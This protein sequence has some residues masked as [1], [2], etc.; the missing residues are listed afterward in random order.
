MQDSQ[1]LKDLQVQL[2]RFISKLEELERENKYLKEQVLNQQCQLMQNVKIIDAKYQ[3]IHRKQIKQIKQRYLKCLYKYG[4]F[5]SCLN[6]MIIQ[7]NKLIDKFGIDDTI[8]MD[9]K[10]C[11]EKYGVIY[12]KNKII[13]EDEMKII[14]NE[15]IQKESEEIHTLFFPT[16]VYQYLTDNDS[17]Q[18]T[19]TFQSLQSQRVRMQNSMQNTQ[20]MI[21]DNSDDTI[22]NNLTTQRYLEKLQFDYQ[23]D[24]TLHYPKTFKV[25]KLL[26]QTNRDL[27]LQNVTDRSQKSKFDRKGDSK[28]E[29]FRISPHKSQN[30]S[31]LE[32]RLKRFDNQE[33]EGGHPRRRSRADRIKQQQ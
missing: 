31:G 3:Q 20:E 6:S 11:I 32:D 15:R 27:S 17:L 2:N 4:T 26:Q 29:Q 18:N 7:Y 1:N 13:D 28:Q 25:E 23:N 14:I 33:N 24:Q 10:S 12:E 30:M 21:T 22:I 9:L 8:K 19:C 16:K 5:Q